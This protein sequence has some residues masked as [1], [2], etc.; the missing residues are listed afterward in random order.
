M[1]V[2]M[3]QF[4]PRLIVHD[5]VLKK[6]YPAADAAH[7]AAIMMQ[8][9][10]SRKITRT[11]VYSLRSGRGALRHRFK[12][13]TPVREPRNPNDIPMPSLDQAREIG[14]GLSTQ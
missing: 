11:M 14:S 2:V 12:I 9:G 4:V 7:A 8:M 10:W 3:P 5:I 1:K 13:I 6:K